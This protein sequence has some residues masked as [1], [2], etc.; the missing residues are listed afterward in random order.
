MNN[1]VLPTSEKHEVKIETA[2]FD[3]GR[4]FGGRPGQYSYEFF[5]HL[6][7]SPIA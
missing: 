7:V 5:L 4:E 2:I 6:E 1:D 3:N